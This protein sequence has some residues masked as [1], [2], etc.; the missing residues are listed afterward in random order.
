MTVSAA[1]LTY[2]SAGSVF[3]YAALKGKTVLGVIEQVT[4]GKSPATASPAM[5]ITSQGGQSVSASGTSIGPDSANG[6]AAA[7]LLYE[8]HPYVY[9]GP[10]NPVSGWDCSSFVS[11]VLGHDAGMGIPGGTWNKVTNGGESHGPVAA[12]YLLWS[13]ASGIP[14]GSVTGGD[15]LC[16]QSHVGFAADSQHMISAY[17]TQ[18]GTVVTAIDGAGPTGEVL[19]CRRLNAY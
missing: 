15:L 7:A 6:I 17:D 11:Y 4:R 3:L 14:R 16:W 5:P 13:G 1:G 18:M 8:G 9:G 2:L 12:S 19:F 10:S